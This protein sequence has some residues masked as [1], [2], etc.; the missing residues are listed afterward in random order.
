MRILSALALCLTLALF[1]PPAA[2]NAQGGSQY[3]VVENGAQAGPFDMAQ[4]QQRALAGTLNK[5]TLVWT[6]G[7]QDW[8][9]AGSLPE[10]ASLF[11]AAP[12][13]PPPPGNDDVTVPGS[14]PQLDQL[15]Q[16]ELQDFGVPATGQ[17][18]TGQMHGKT[19]ASIPGG[20]VITTKEL[21]TWVANERPFML[22]DV[23]Y[24][25]EMLPGAIDAVIAANPGSY[26]DEISQ[27]MAQYL[28]QA[29]GGDKSVPLV[30][31]CL[32]IDCWMS[33]NAAL[34]AIN[35]GYT[36]VKWY[37]GGIEAWKTA[38][39]PVQQRSQAGQQPQQLM[40]AQ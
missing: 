22:F 38:G 5:Q 3:Y 36:N 16:M 24:G 30:F 8:Q 37:R 6:S 4:L 27:Q 18:H 28:Q 40:P 14:N 10:L 29:L 39:M 32:S 2:A 20:Q 34:R 13:P 33:Y 1:L 26:G 25:A 17:L 12:P 7:M 31:Y 9:P 35:L 21:L 19:P 23:L 15:A 11:A